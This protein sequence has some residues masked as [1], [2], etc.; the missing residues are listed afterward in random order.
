MCREGKIEPIIMNR[1][2]PLGCP[3][4]KPLDLP[5]IENA[6]DE[7]ILSVHRLYKSDDDAEEC[8]ED[9]KAK[10]AAL[11]ALIEREK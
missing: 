11:M 4:N 9:I 2:C 1:A 7:V 6:V 5:A 3:G 10:R 8:E